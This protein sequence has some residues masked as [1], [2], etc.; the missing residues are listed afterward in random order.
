MIQARIF[1]ATAAL[2][3][4]LSMPAFAEVYRVVNQDN[5]AQFLIVDCPQ[6]PQG[7]D[8]TWVRTNCKDA[9]TAAA[10]ARDSIMVIGWNHEVVAP[11]DAN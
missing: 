2:A 8:F 11:R 4:A 3:L 10:A 1:A 7:R 5:P 9:P 6:T